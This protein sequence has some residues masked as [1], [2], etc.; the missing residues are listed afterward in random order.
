LKERSRVRDRSVPDFTD[1]AIPVRSRGQEL[2]IAG[3]S[4]EPSGLRPDVIWLH[5]NGFNARTYRNTLAPLGD[6]LKVLAIDQRGHG[7]TPQA[8]EAGGK[9]DALDMRD[10]LLAL[11]DVVAP[12]RSVILAG[13]SLGGCVSLLAAGEAPQRVRALALFDPVILSQ[14]AT[15]AARSGTGFAISESPLVQKARGRRREF[16][17]RAEAFETY[18][19]RSIFAT[20]PEQAVR[21]YIETG[22]RDLAS[23]GVELSCAPEWEAAN[24]AA[25]GHDIWTAMSAITAPVRIYRADQG[26]TCS[27][28][29]ASEFPRPAGQVEV[30]TVPGAT[31]FLPIERP[32]LVRQA[33]LDIETTTPGR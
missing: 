9:R 28:V 1:V 17:S 24:F 15:S 3:S 14:A 25:H 4:T 18:R 32:D 33:L 31:H 30:S 12:D 13:H 23:G 21:D 27:I 5:A 6:R 2:V 10:D 20:W 22:F 11:L 19:R 16:A 26:S 7:R 29:Q 8:A